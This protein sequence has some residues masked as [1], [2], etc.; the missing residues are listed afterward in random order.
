MIGEGEREGGD[1]REEAD[2]R[3]QVRGIASSEREAGE[4]RNPK[5]LERII[6]AD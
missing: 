5:K 6:L 2:E 3:R 1:T 4:V